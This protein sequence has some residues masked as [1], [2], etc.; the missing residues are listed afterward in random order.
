VYRECGRRPERESQ[1]L[2][3]RQ[4]GRELAGLVRMPLLTGM[5]RSLRRPARAAGFGLLQAFL[6]EGLSSFR[7]LHN[8]RLFVESI[9]EREWRAMNLLFSGNDDPFIRL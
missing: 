2:L 6:E 3:I 9:F 1:I 5:L 7:Q 8:A 4:L